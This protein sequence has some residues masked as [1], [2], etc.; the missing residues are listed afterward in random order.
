MASLLTNLENNEA[1]L[2][3]YLANEL[4][5]DDRAEVESLLQSDPQFGAQLEQLRQSYVAL[6]SAIG[7][8][9][10]SLHLSSGFSSARQFGEA[11]RKRYEALASAE[12]KNTSPHPRQIWWY[13]LATAAI[14]AIGMSIWWYVASNQDQRFIDPR[15]EYVSEE[16]TTETPASAYVSRMF[17]PFPE[18]ANQT[19]LRK[20]LEVVKYLRTE[21]L[22]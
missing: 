12:D 11:V 2:L 13:P 1:V 7:Q 4:P 8:A 18:D 6:D 5:A 16:W 22:W 20:E 14:V 21:T 15:E 17:T 10:A 9:D 3:M 19:E